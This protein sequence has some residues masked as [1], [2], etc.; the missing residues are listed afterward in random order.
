MPIPDFKGSP[1]QTSADSAVRILS[2]FTVRCLSVKIW[3]F[4]SGGFCVRI[5]NLNFILTDRQRTVIPDRI[6][7][8][9]SADI[10]SI[11]K[12]FYFWNQYRIR[13]F[14]TF[15]SKIKWLRSGLPLI[16]YLEVKP[17]SITIAYRLRLYQWRCKAFLN[18][19]LTSA[20]SLM[21]TSVY[22]LTL[23]NARWSVSMWTRDDRSVCIRN[24]PY[25]E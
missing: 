11:P 25:K 6:R 9:L 23:F 7:T 1:Y 8:A 20:W 21:V 16:R 19:N 3:N 17:Y 14:S 12:P 10:W 2:G 13:L 24:Q 15:I 4:Q 18:L 5:S 22:C